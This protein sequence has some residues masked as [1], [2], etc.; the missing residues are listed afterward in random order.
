MSGPDHSAEK[1]RRIASAVYES[2]KRLF[3]QCAVRITQ[4]RELA[5]DAVHEAFVSILEHPEKLQTMSEHEI[6]KWCMV[7]V[8]HKAIDQ[9]RARSRLCHVPEEQLTNVAATTDSLDDIVVNQELSASVR[10]YLNAL[11]AES[12]LILEMKYGLHMR[13]S[14]IAAQLHVSEKYVDNHMMLAK[15]KLRKWL[16]QEVHTDE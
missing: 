6:L 1:A 10:S 5:E 3:F 4:N 12:R 13:Y 14:E 15:R 7:I 8:K 16:E 2:H 9:L 11:D